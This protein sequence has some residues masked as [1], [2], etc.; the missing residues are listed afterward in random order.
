M[1]MKFNMFGRNLWPVVFLLA[2]TMCG[3]V[4]NKV[5]VIVNKEGGGN[6]VVT[7]VFSKEAVEMMNIQIAEMKRS[8]G[9]R[10]SANPLTMPKDP[11]FNEKA[12]KKDARKF[13]AAKFVKARKM[14]SCGTRGY[15]AVYSFNDIN[16]VFLDIQNLGSDLQRGGGMQMDYSSGN[17]EDDEPFSGKQERGEGAVEF[18]FV[19]I[20]SPK[21]EIISQPIPISPEPSEA[22]DES[23]EKDKVKDSEEEEQEFMM[24]SAMSYPGAYGRGGSGREVMSAMFT[25]AGRDDAET[26]MAKG[27]EFSIAVEVDGAVSKNTASI[28]D[29]VKKNRVILMEMNLDKMLA[30]PAGKKLGG[31]LRYASPDRMYAHLNKMPGAA[32]ET[33]RNVVIEF[34]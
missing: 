7:R 25:G 22:D 26:R 13:G 32:M 14:A 1:R 9:A 34:K 3:C 29:P 17:E 19:K 16:D 6:I 30:S 31:S 11:F 27:T 24:E 20:A 28:V 23:E 33:N 15:V 8:M 2:T 18:K 10:L 4:K 21:L 5:L 12:L